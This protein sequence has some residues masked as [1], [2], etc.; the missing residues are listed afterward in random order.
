MSRSRSSLSKWRPSLPSDRSRYESTLDQY[1]HCFTKNKLS[2]SRN[3]NLKSETNKLRPVTGFRFVSRKS[4]GSKSELPTETKKRIREIL[5]QLFSEDGEP[6]CFVTVEKQLLGLMQMWAM[7]EAVELL[8]ESVQIGVNPDRTVVLNLLQQLANL[9]EVECLLE[10][11][12]FLKDRGLSTNLK[13]YHCLRDAYFNSGRVEDGVLMLR[14][15]YHSNR[16]FDDT[17]LLFTLLATMTARHF[18]HMLPLI[19]S[20]VIDLEESDPPVV[21]ARASL[22]CCL[23]LAE[24]FEKADALLEEFPDVKKMVAGQITKVVQ[25]PLEL[26]FDRDC[27]L[28]WLMNSPYVKPGLAASL[29][30]L[31]ILHKSSQGQWSEGLAY[32]SKAMD[33]GRKVHQKTV[34][35]FL[36]RFLQQLPMNQIKELSAWAGSLQNLPED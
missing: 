27:V 20:F 21:S 11:H 17:D 15:I 36:E 2:R 14:M 26:D 25:S 9:G 32:L 10:L 34:E 16:D 7:E 6:L 12:E 31:L 28:N 22:W 19:E 5:P 24:Q 35:I 18:E 29:F 3:V 8:K 23:V 1:R 4:D 13:F 33:E 30:D